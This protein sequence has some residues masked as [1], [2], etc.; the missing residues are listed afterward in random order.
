MVIDKFPYIF[1][2][3]VKSSLKRNQ[4]FR[5]LKL[6]QFDN[7]FDVRALFFF[8][9]IKLKHEI[10]TVLGQLLQEYTFRMG[11]GFQAWKFLHPL[12]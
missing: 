3:F 7:F 4:I 12:G 1:K 11:L 5:K 9:L 6:L 2:N 8:K 10:E